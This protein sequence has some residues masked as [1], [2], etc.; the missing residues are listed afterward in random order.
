M[1]LAKDTYVGNKYKDK[2]EQILVSDSSIKTERITNI[3]EEIGYWRKANAIHN[4]F[5]KNLDD[6]A[7]NCKDCYVEVEHLEK[8]LETVNKVLEVSKLV[9]GKIQNGSIF[10]DGKEIPIMVDGKCI[11]DPTV[12]KKLLPTT[13]GCFFG[14]IDY[15]EYYIQQLEET[16]KILEESLEEDNGDFY[17]RASW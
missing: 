2:K 11:E 13:E 8:L 17:Y 12:A 1:Y 4:W 7:D 5:V 15:N 16:K 3:R 14:S 9:N 6:D 10:K